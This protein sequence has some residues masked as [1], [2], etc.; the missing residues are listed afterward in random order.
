MRATEPAFM[1]AFL[2]YAAVGSLIVSRRF[3][4]R[5][6]LALSSAL[7]LVFELG[8]LAQEYAIYALRWSSEALPAA[9]GPACWRIASRSSRPVSARSCF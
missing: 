1:V 7:G 9:R 4:N 5:R 2:A 6:R 3:G 8:L